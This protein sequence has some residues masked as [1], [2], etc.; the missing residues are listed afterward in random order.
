MLCSPPFFVPSVYFFF[1]LFQG[2]SFFLSLSFFFTFVTFPLGCTQPQIFVC[3]CFRFVSLK[4]KVT[5]PLIF[6]FLVIIFNVYKTL[7]YCLAVFNLHL[8][9]IFSTVPVTPRLFLPLCSL[10]PPPPLNQ[11]TQVIKRK[12]HTAKKK[13]K[14]MEMHR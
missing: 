6:F 2:F 10:F 8:E 1:F 12:C 5:D 4:M 14:K 13:R 3:S 11:Q 9:N 7:F